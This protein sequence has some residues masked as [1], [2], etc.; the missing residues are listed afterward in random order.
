MCAATCVAQRASPDPRG[1][2]R[3]QHWTPPSRIRLRGDDCRLLIV[4]GLGGKDGRKACGAPTW[5]LW[6][7]RLET[8]WLIWAIRRGKA[9]LSA[10]LPSSDHCLTE[11]SGMG[12]SLGG[13]RRGDRCSTSGPPRDDKLEQADV[14]LGG[15][16]GGTAGHAGGPRTSTPHLPHLHGALERFKNQ[17]GSPRAA[18]PGEFP[19]LEIDALTTA[20]CGPP[21][22]VSRGKS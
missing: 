7:G 19:D 14:L 12:L 4:G 9:R 22:S 10:W 15:T 3:S 20:I 1:A 2:L 6:P 16:A 17:S 21:C 5:L 18:L 11:S 8:P 13:D